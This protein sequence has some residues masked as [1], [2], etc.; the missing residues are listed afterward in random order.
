MELKH[1]DLK[2][3]IV[4]IKDLNLVKLLFWKIVKI[5]FRNESYK[6][7]IQEDALIVWKARLSITFT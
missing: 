3:E 1:I 4:L 5:K 6:S 7:I 2:S